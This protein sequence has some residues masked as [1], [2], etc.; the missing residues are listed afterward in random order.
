VRATRSLS[1]TRDLRG[2]CRYGH[3]ADIR[4]VLEHGKS[5]DRFSRDSDSYGLTCTRRWCSDGFEIGCDNGERGWFALDCCDRDAMSSGRHGW[6]LRQG[7]PRPDGRGRRAS[8]RPGQSL[9]VTIEWLTD[10]G[11]CP[12]PVTPAAPPATSVLS[13]ERHRSKVR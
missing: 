11:S 9:A 13:R 10:N 5:G 12:S 7:H 6:H 1:S 3:H 2:S 4:L 8:L